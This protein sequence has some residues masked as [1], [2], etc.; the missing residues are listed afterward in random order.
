[1]AKKPVKVVAK[2]TSRALKVENT[3]K[4]KA[5]RLEKHL[6]AHPNDL[7]SFEKAKLTERKKP[8]NKGSA[9]AKKFF[10]YDEA[11]HKTEIEITPRYGSK[12]K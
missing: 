8:F 2:D 12:K 9:P 6:K 3:R 11:G 10:A 1:M 7:Q 5:A 4:R